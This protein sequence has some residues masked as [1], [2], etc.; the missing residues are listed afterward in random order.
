MKRRA[1]STLAIL[2]LLLG[3]AVPAAKAA[4]P[5]DLP[6][7]LS[8]AAHTEIL[9]GDATFIAADT[10]AATGCGRTCD[11]KNPQTY[12]IYHS[13]CS[14]CYHYCADDAVTKR[15]GHHSSPGLELRYSARCRTAWTKVSTGNSYPWVE[16]RYLDG[17]LRMSTGNFAGSYYT[18]MVDDAGLLAYAYVS[19]GPTTWYTSGY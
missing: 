6:R 1:I 5:P 9:S 2:G 14:T 18:N 12:K 4:S 7:S 10:L 13:G 15:W 19:Q 11:N 3:G 17:R 8:A 16:S